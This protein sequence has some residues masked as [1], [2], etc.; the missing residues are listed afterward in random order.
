MSRAEFDAHVEKALSESLN[1]LEARAA[2]QQMERDGWDVVTRSDVDEPYH[3]VDFGT[4]DVTACQVSHVRRSKGR[5]VVA[6]ADGEL[7]TFWQ[8]SKHAD[9]FRTHDVLRR[10][11]NQAVDSHRVILFDV[12][13]GSQTFKGRHFPW[14]ESLHKGKRTDLDK[15]VRSKLLEILSD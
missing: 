6:R 9:A 3:V 7:V 14:K 1:E 4:H 8:F 12:A 11:V 2:H 15:E 5:H 10:S 13:T